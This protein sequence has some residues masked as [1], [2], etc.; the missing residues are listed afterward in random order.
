MARFDAQAVQ[1]L[2]DSLDDAAARTP[3]LYGAIGFFVGAAALTYVGVQLLPAYSWVGTLVGAIVGSILGMS[4][5]QERGFTMKSEAL[6]L[7]GQIQLERNTR[8]EKAPPVEAQAASAS[9]A[10]REPPAI[11]KAVLSRPVHKESA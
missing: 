7:L 1:E 5:G 11:Q 3:G 4:V 2:A 9:S 8:K 6:A 10:R